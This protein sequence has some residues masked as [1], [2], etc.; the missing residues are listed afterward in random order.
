[1]AR[2]LAAHGRV[3]DYHFENGLK[4]LIFPVLLAAAVAQAQQL[5]PRAYSNVPVGMNFFIAGYTYSSGGLATDPVQAL[6]NAQL[7]IHEPLIA[8]ARAFDA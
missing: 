5:E 2:S 4:S 1:M 7:D 3:R 8:Y 6:D